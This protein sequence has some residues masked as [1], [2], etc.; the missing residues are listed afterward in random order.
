M[1]YK[2][3]PRL[4]AEERLMRLPELNFDRA[5]FTPQQAWAHQR[6][7]DEQL[8]MVRLGMFEQR[9]IYHFWAFRV[10]CGSPPCQEPVN[11]P[12]NI[13]DNRRGRHCAC[14]GFRLNGLMPER[15][16]PPRD[17]ERRIVSAPQRGAVYLTGVKTRVWRPARG[18]NPG[19]A[20]R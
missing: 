14:P 20:I 5:R 4:T 12:K 9:P 3:M 8:E 10:S 17:R 7:R 1:V 16:C 15:Q 19:M 2:R 18:E 13:H 6:S 11:L